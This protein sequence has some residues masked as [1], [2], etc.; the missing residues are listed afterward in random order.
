MK[1]SKLSDVIKLIFITNDG[2]WVSLSSDAIR[3]Y[4]TINSKMTPA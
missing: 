2:N 4:I 3:I 1:F